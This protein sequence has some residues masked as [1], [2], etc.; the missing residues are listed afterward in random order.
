[1]NRME[2]SAAPDFR[3]TRRERGRKSALG[4]RE[5][6]KSF[7]DAVAKTRTRWKAQLREELELS[8][9]LD[10]LAQPRE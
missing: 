8:E 10:V 9:A 6:N 2:H 5:F 7:E 3:M 4:S 1:M